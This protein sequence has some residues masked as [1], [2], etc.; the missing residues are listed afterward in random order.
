MRTAR[1]PRR[2]ARRAVAFALAALAS[3]LAL[4]LCGRVYDALHF[5]YRRRMLWEVQRSLVEDERLGFT[6]R[7]GITW[8]EERSF[9]W[10]DHAVEPMSTDEWGFRNHPDAIEARRAGAPIDV[11][12]LG[13]SFVEDAA[14]LFHEELAR[15]G[16]RYYGLAIC[17]HAP[18]QYNRALQGHGLALHPRNV[19][20]AVFEN[21]AVET[22][23]FEAWEASGSGWFDYHSGSWAGPA[24]LGW[25]SWFPGIHRLRTRVLGPESEPSSP[26]PAE[27]AASVAGYVRDARRAAREAGAGFLLV[28]VPSRETVL[29]GDTPGS[30]FHDALLERLRED[31]VRTLDLRLLF[32]SSAEPAALYYE[33]DTHWNAA[34]MRLG[35]EA[36][37]GAL[38]E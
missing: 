26:S 33:Q 17:R 24:R 7:P 13:D 3:V 14:Y 37:R 1:T 36:I 16:L 4:E 21:D 12:G 23:D 2:R 22:R 25:R 32:R 30:A 11:L 31:G 9:P 19:V 28:L 18:P 29:A 15:D 27:G 34:G 20:Y 10:L 8:A 6:W 35:L 38:G 5:R